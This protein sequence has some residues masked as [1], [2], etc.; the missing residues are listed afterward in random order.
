MHLVPKK[1]Q[2]TND[3]IDIVEECSKSDLRESLVVHTKH[4][5]T[6][7]VC[8]GYSIFISDWKMSKLCV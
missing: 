8:Y 2:Q 7:Y 1:K 6:I 3:T 4:I 5:K